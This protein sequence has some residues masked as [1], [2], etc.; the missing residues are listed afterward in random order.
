VKRKKKESI[1]II[2]NERKYIS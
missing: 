2:M 1:I